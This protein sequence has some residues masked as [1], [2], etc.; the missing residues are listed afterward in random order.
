MADN[1]NKNANGKKN[2]WKLTQK[3]LNTTRKKVG[4]ELAL[5]RENAVS[6]EMQTDARLCRACR[7]GVNCKQYRKQKREKKRERKRKQKRLSY[8][9]VIAAK[10]AK[11]MARREEKK[12]K[13]GETCQEESS[14][15][16]TSDSDSEPDSPEP[17]QRERAVQADR[18]VVV[19]GQ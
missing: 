10:V 18:R 14:E 9:K 17:P 2:V 4:R 12:A 15:D 8:L 5:A 1:G 7:K 13:K 16:S 19:L 11:K 3:D 6:T